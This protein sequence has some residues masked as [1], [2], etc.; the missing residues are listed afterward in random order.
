[1]MEI[2]KRIL[3]LFSGQ[4]GK[5]DSSYIIE[6]PTHE[7]TR[8]DINENNIYRVAVVTAA[9][10]R[11][12]ERES[13]SHHDRSDMD[14][15]EPPVSEGEHVTVEIE[16]IG[17]KGDGI[18]RVERGFVVIVPDTEL[19]ERVTVTITDVRENLAF[20]EVVKRDAYYE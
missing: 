19:H 4:V 8:G 10:S 20:S 11:E 5:R 14:R 16:D 1:M 12:N 7:L 9:S 17:D 2:S 18:A 13:K 3:C 15:L 6:I